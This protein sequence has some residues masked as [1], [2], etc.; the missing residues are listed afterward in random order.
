M[1]CSGQLRAPVMNRP[2]PQAGIFQGSKYAIMASVGIS[3]SVAVYPN[4][5]D[6]ARNVS[7]ACRKAIH[8]SSSTKQRCCHQ[9]QHSSVKFTAQTQL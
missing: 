6:I 4:M 5:L 9:L 1:C 8:T 7:S 3:T 2:M